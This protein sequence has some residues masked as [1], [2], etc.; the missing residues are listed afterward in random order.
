MFNEKPK[1]IENGTYYFLDNILKQC[2]VIKMNYYNKIFN[3]GLFILFVF[4]LGLFLT[5]R[6]KGRLSDEEIEEK[7]REKELY[8]LSKIK[9]YQ[10]GRQ[11]IRNEMI[12]GLPEWENEQ[13]YVLRKV[14][15]K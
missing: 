2:H 1:L 12:T 15:N 7:N 5:Y 8:I 13:E 14:V 10:S 4:V 6:Y 11:R 9:N 3:V